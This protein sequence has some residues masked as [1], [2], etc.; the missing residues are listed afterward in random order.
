MVCVINT[1]VRPIRS[2]FPQGRAP[3]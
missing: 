1:S 3:R 2:L